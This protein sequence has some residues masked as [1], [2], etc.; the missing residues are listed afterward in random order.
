MSTPKTTVGKPPVLRIAIYL[1]FSQDRS[2][3]GLGM[4]R[5]EPHCRKLAEEIAAQRGAI[6]QITV[7]RDN[8]ISASRYSRKK[9]ADYAAMCESIERGELD[10]VVSYHHD[11]LLRDK[12][13]EMEPFIDLIERNRVDVQFCT[14]GRWELHTATGRF[15]ARIAGSVAAYESELKSERIKLQR[16]QQAMAG[17]FHGGRRPY[18]FEA[19]GVT[20]R[21]DEAR[22]IVR[23]YEQVVAGVSLR[24]IVR[25]LNTRGVPTATGS[26]P[27]SSTTVRDLLRARRNG[28]WSVHLG[29]V[30]GKAEWPALVGEDVWLAANAVLDNPARRTTPGAIPKWLGSGLY[31]CGVCGHAQLRVGVSGSGRRPSYRCRSRETT[32]QGHVSRD[33]GQVDA[34]VEQTIV[35][36]LEQP[37]ALE[38]LRAGASTG[39]TDI[40]AL[41]LEQAA[42]R[43]R[44]DTM[45][46]LFSEGTIDERQLVS[47]T[48][49]LKTKISEIDTTLAAAGMRSPLDELTGKGPNIRAAWF[50]TQPDR[51]D[52]LSLG[53]RR[54]IVDMLAVV[55]I[56]PAPKGRRVSGEYFDPEFVSIEWKR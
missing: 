24:Q 23:M 5:H 31:L 52:G 15:Q 51:S 22:E 50:G 10:V 14:A 28:G 25:D 19:D 7:Y 27:W 45:A 26:A 40:A 13:K 56:L 21:Q 2:G 53:A 48:G 42:L 44:L 36:R 8:D 35:T 54:A 11:R 33:A 32:G 29:E 49:D 18:G 47:G 38:A 4:A 41:R 3:E 20:V 30:V 39:G 9:R 34:L 55:T 17:K 37:D 1:R 46:R 6:P 43:Q 16:V 12:G